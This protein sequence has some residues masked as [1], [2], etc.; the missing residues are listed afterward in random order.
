MNRYLSRLTFAL[1]LLCA[2]VAHAQTVDEIVA[3]NLQA[4]GGAERWQAVKSVKMAGSLIVQ[5]RKMPL[6]VY[7]KRPNF[8]RQ[9]ITTPNGQVIQAFDGTT[10]WVLNPMM[11]SA[12]QAAPA[13]TTEIMKN[14]ADFD[15]ALLNYKEKGHAIEFIGTEKLG[16]NTVHHLKVT[17]KGGHVQHYFLDAQTGIELKTSAEIVLMSGEKQ[18]VDT[19]MSNYKTIGGIMIPHS[20]KQVVDGKTI[21]EMAITSVEFNAPIEDELFHMP[22]Q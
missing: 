10:A 22:K 1:A 7:A 3:K 6:T 5:G 9:E 14:T 11:S 20:V 2:G 18:A 8:H 15:G 21:M 4:K 19:E 13:A 17:M 16:E 12:P